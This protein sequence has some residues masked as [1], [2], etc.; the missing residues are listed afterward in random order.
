M[1][2]LAYATLSGAF[3]IEKFELSA[4]SVDIGH[5]ITLTFDITPATQEPEVN[6]TW[7]TDYSVT[8]YFDDCNIVDMKPVER[9]TS[10][11]T[12]LYRQVCTIPSNSSAYFN[13][14]GEVYCYAW[15]K[16]SENTTYPAFAYFNVTGSTSRPPLWGDDDSRQD[17]DDSSPH[18]NATLFIE[19]FE[20][21]ATSVDIGHNITLTFDI[22]PATQEPEVN[23]TWETDYSVTG[24]FDDCN[25][26]DMKPVERNTS[27][28]TYLYRQVCT[29]PSNSSA[30]FNGEGEVYCYA[31]DKSSENTTYP[32]FAY[33]N[34]TGSTSR[35]P[36][37]G[38]DD[39]RQDDDDSSPRPNVTEKCIKGT[40]WNKAACMPC[41]AGT[42]SKEGSETCTPCPA[43]KYSSFMSEKCIS[44]EAGTYAQMGQASCTMCPSGTFSGAGAGKCSACANGAFSGP[45]ASVCDICAS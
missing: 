11:S 3:E 4:T 2:L 29:I 6:C 42:Y 14:E 35:P 24:Y 30:Y 19:K 25:I 34:V 12:Y 7:E 21:S 41:G 13:G 20:L 23:C 10:T 45:G 16:S 38:D 44:C 33:F 18:P 17:D 26:V 40:F 31:W 28:S 8:G 39:S 15:D 9:N 37:W 22:T 43:G 1:M 27:T 36:L 5:N 32:A